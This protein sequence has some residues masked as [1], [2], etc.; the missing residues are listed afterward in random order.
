LR[1]IDSKIDTLN[2]LTFEDGDTIPT[3]YSAKAFNKSKIV[4]NN[5]YFLNK[6][7]S[8]I[9]DKTN[10]LFITNII[11]KTSYKFIIP[12][13]ITKKVFTNTFPNGMQKLAEVEK[14]YTVQDQKHELSISSF[15]VDSNNLYLMVNFS[16]ILEK[17][18]D[19]LDT[20]I[21][22]ISTLIVYKNGKKEPLI[23]YLSKSGIMKDYEIME[24]NINVQGN[25]I[26]IDVMTDRKNYIKKTFWLCKCQLLQNLVFDTSTCI[27]RPKIHHELG[28]NHNFGNYI[29]I[30][31]YL[32]N[33][34]SN[35]LINHHTKA[36]KEL[37]I[38]FKKIIYD[39]F[40][41]LKTT[42]PY[43]LIDIKIKNKEA[44]I[45]YFM[46]DSYN[47]VK[48]DL[49]LNKIIESTVL[50][51]DVKP[52]RTAPKFFSNNLIYYYLKSGNSILLKEIKL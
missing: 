17:S 13:E 45:I 4:G 15:D 48:Y 38:P 44:Q 52:L 19:Y 40:E 41:S 25:D 29:L 23:Y 35:E 22:K 32:I 46:D 5:V 47:Y 42:L 36:S 3:N 27:S 24:G 49:V 31:D 11:N 8:Y 14:L 21:A 43:N 6:D 39:R 7:F 26:F 51:N 37:N 12:Y 33:T 50:F 28:L 1:N 16:Y 18:E 30:E 2:Y 34:I 10:A 9:Y 20:T